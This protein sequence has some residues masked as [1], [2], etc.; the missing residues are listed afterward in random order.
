MQFFPYNSGIQNLEALGL[1]S[2][3]AENVQAGF[4]NQIA[5]FDIIVL[6]RFDVSFHDLPSCLLEDIVRFSVIDQ[7]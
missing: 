7:E 2:F 3:P 4:L 1:I 5:C 6:L